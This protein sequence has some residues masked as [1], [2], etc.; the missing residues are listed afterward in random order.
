M[1]I[2]I[3]LPRSALLLATLYLQTGTLTSLQGPEAGVT[4]LIAI[5]RNHA[6]IRDA[7]HLENKI[8]PLEARGDRNRA[9]I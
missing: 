1:C 4:L 3:Y 9:L 2:Y 8:Q 5:I 6:F 7:D